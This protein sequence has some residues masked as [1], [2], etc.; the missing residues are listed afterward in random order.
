L[1]QDYN[2]IFRKGYGLYAVTDPF[3]QQSWRERVPVVAPV[4]S[5]KQLPEN[6]AATVARSRLSAEEP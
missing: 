6:P 3:V 4:S 1:L 2:L 5:E